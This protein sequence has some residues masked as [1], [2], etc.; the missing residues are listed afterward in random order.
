M[1]GLLDALGW[2]DDELARLAHGNW[3]RVLR[4]TWIV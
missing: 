4:A 1:Q 3:L 2:S